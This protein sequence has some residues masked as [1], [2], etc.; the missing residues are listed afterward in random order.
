MRAESLIS[1][2][3]DTPVLAAAASIRP[4]TAAARCAVLTT[5]TP[6]AA[7]ACADSE[8]ENDLR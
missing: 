7:A 6:E 3:P 8:R 1:A 2:R 5:Y 4:L